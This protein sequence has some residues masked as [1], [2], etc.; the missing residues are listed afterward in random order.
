MTP[1]D[2]GIA[3]AAVVMMLSMT[4][5]VLVWAFRLPPSPTWARVWTKAALALVGA[6]ELARRLDDLDPSW[7]GSLVWLNLAASAIALVA[8]AWT[9]SRVS[10]TEAA[11]VR[12]AE[13]TERTATATERI[14]Q[15]AAA[16]DFRVERRAEEADARTE[17]RSAE[18]DARTEAR[19]AEADDR[20]ER[21]G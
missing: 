1:N 12:T 19:S 3:A 18:A 2:V 7:W 15:H 14:E 16:T 13:A 8:G 20:M 6:R 17:A 5:A 4:D 10:R 9:G 21:R 11:L